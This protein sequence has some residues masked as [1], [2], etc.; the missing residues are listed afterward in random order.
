MPP[1]GT[2]PRDGSRQGDI[3]LSG[4]VPMKFDGGQMMRFVR[5]WKPVDFRLPSESRQCDHTM[6]QHRT[7]AEHQVSSVRVSVRQVQ[8]GVGVHMQAVLAHSPL[9]RL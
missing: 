2:A 1:I 6:I 8:I 5:I 7:A 4:R 3:D 9:P